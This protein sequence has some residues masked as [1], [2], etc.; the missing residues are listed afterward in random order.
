VRIFLDVHGEVLRRHP[1]LPSGTLVMEHRGPAGPERRARAAA[2]G[3]P[4]TVQQPLPH[5][6]AGVEREFWGPERVAAGFPAPGRLDQGS[7]WRPDPTPL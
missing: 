5:D 7:W 3:V 1:G 6:T 2:P 4:V